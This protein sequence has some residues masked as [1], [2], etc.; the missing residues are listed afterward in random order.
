MSIDFGRRLVL[1][2]IPLVFG[3][4]AITAACTKAKF[5]YTDITGVEI[6]GDFQLTDHN[7]HPRSLSDFRGKVVAVFFG[8]T[9]CPDVCPTTLAELAQTVRRLGARGDQVQI[10]F[11]TVDP[12]RDTQKVLAQYVP[13][14]DPR[15]LGLYGDLA[16]TAK[17]A[18]AT[19]AVVARSPYRPKTRGSKAGT[20][21]A[22]T[23]CVSLAGSTVMNRIWTWSPLAP[24]RLT[25]CA[26]SASVVGHT[27]G[28]CV[29]PKNTATTFPRKSE[30]DRGWPLWSVS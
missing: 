11:I 19:L 24:S 7:G 18:A 15:V 17:V 4:A 14:F 5:E 21:C 29:N 2:R 28:Q 1:L 8:F 25:V 27:S 3:S 26:S 12:A 6:G 10:L 22:S 9:H 20:Y 30:S 13:A 16:T 23:F